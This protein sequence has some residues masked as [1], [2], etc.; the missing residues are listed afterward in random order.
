MHECRSLAGEENHRALEVVGPAPAARRDAADG[1]VSVGKTS[2]GK[3][4][5][6]GRKEPMR[7]LRGGVA[8][9]EDIHVDDP[10]VTP[11]YTYEPSTY[12]DNVYDVSGSTDT[13]CVHC[14][15]SEDDGEPANAPEPECTGEETTTAVPASQP[16]PDNAD[17]KP[18]SDN[19][20]DAAAVAGLASKPTL[21]TRPTAR[22]PETNAA[23]RRGRGAAL[24]A[25]FGG[26]GG[27]EGVGMDVGGWLKAD[28]SSAR[29]A[30]RHGACRECGPDQ[31]DCQ[32]SG[33][34]LCRVSSRTGPIGRI[35][36]GSVRNPSAIR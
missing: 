7:A 5:V 14:A 21:A 33:P 19:R 26:A 23:V 2:E 9:S 35:R 10:P 20:F 15:S 22:T 17:S 8:V 27:T 11:R 30:P 31:C 25:R 13:V 29:N 34:L 6:G 28:V 36:P 32:G 4:T 12:P 18:G 16:H 24:R 3:A 1:W